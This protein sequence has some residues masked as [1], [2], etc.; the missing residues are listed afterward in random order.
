MRTKIRFAVAALAAGAAFGAQAVNNNWTGN[1]AVDGDWFQA[2]N[3]TLDHPPL[4]AEDVNLDP[5]NYADAIVISNASQTAFANTLNASRTRLDIHT[6]LAVTNLYGYGYY[7]VLTQYGGTVSCRNFIMGVHNYPASTE[8]TYRLEGGVLRATAS[9]YMGRWSIGHFEQTGGVVE[10]N[11]TPNGVYDKNGSSYTISGGSLVATNG[12]FYCG[13]V[14]SA[15]TT[16]QYLNLEGGTVKLDTLRVGGRH[17]QG[18]LTVAGG[19]NDIKT[20]ALGNW[21]SSKPILILR[22]SPDAGARFTVSG[23]VTFGDSTYKPTVALQAEINEHGVIPLTI[24]G[25]VTV[26]PNTTFLATAVDADPGVYTV[27]TWG[28][29]LSGAANLLY[30][31]ET[32]FD[33]IAY[34]LDAVGKTLKVKVRALETVI[35]IR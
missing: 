35:S 21:A 27:M 26:H 3:W 12:T 6:D 15:S 17:A 28:G 4:A 29:T 5:N 7:P 10:L 11:G 34:T 1:P 20:L 14:S 13:D 19:T 9:F 30:G 25:N 2:S 23:N 33:R 8:A 16:R 22:G 31:A 18:T 24:Q 32:D